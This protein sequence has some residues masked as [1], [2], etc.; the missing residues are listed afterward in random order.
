MFY[1]L[2]MLSFSEKIGFI[3]NAHFKMPL[4]CKWKRWVFFF[5]TLVLW[6]PSSTGHCHSAFSLPLQRQITTS[7]K[8]RNIGHKT[9]ELKPKRISHTPHTLTKLAHKASRKVPRFPSSNSDSPLTSKSNNKDSSIWDFACVYTSSSWYA[10]LKDSQG[11]SG[12]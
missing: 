7:L 8:N 11:H 9:G 3:D 4:V 10:A 2:L 1:F 6:Y 5:S 12:A